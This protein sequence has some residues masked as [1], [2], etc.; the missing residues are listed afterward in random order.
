MKSGFHAMRSKMSQWNSTAAIRAATSDT[1]VLK[2]LQ[3]GVTAT[4]C[5]LSYGML[6]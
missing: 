5:T 4:L 6:F 1:L 3:A 2:P